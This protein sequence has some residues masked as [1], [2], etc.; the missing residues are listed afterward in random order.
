MAIA[1]PMLAFTEEAIERMQK[2][3]NERWTALLGCW[4]VSVGCLRYRHITRASPKRISMFFV[5]EGNRR[6]TGRAFTS[7][8]RVSS[9]RVSPGP[10]TGS[11][12]MGPSKNVNNKEPGFVSTGQGSL[13]PLVR[14]S[15]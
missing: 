15:R 8:C 7:Q 5:G 9:A 1:P 2:S 14:W 11:N 12:C 10:N 4:L 3:G 6:L 13:G